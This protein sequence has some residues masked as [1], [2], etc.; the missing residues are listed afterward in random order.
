MCLIIHTYIHTDKQSN[1]QTDGPERPIHAA[2]GVGNNILL[3]YLFIFIYLFTII[4]III[5]ISIIIINDKISLSS[6]KLQE[7]IL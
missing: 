1:K 7:H 2:V 4:I 3:F 5:I 6:A